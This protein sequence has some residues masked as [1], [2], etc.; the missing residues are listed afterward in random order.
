MPEFGIIL[1]EIET[2][3]YITYRFWL[4]QRMWL[5]TSLPITQSWHLVSIGDFLPLL[6]VSIM[7][8][9]ISIIKWHISLRA[10]HTIKENEFSWLRFTA[11]EKPYKEWLPWQRNKGITWGMPAAVSK[12]MKASTGMWGIV[13]RSLNNNEYLI[14]QYCCSCSI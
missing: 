2:P 13:R 11:A 7:D 14:E 1:F 12:E 8:K 9:A 4:L 10:S 3:S 5:V 6:L